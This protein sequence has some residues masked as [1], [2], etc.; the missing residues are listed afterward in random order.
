VVGGV[1]GLLTYNKTQHQYQAI[2]EQIEELTS[3]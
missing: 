3:E 1:F 2:I